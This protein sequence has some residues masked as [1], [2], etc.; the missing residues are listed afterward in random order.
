MRKKRCYIALKD[1][2][3]FM[4]DYNVI[5]MISLVLVGTLGHLHD[6][7]RWRY[8]TTTTRMLCQ[9]PSAN[10]YRILA[11]HSGCCV[12]ITWSCKW[13]IP[14]PFVSILHSGG[15]TRFL[16]IIRWNW[17]M[18]FLDWTAF[19]CS[20]ASQP[21]E[22]KGACLCFSS[23]KHNGASLENTPSQKG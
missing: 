22:P 20:E 5:W 14:I 10:R 13:P 8:V 11:K 7:V 9:H 4:N 19:F 16:V 3:N 1:L 18:F 21:W 12:Q 23:Q 17:N 2:L 6:D 15:I